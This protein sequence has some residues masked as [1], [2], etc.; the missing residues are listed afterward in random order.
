MDFMSTRRPDDLTVCSQ[1][2]AANLDTVSKALAE[3]NRQNA[4]LRGIL[5]AIADMPE[6]SADQAPKLA[7]DI[8]SRI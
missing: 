7:R 4:L 8:L 1:I 5:Q 3:A 6:N 2:C